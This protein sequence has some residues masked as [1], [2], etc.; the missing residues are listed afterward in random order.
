MINDDDND[1]V[2]DVLCKCTYSFYYT[3]FAGLF[4]EPKASVNSHFAYL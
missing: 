4:A 2:P 1:D 3:A